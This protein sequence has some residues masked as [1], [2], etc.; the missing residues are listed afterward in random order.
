MEILEYPRTSHRAN[1]DTG[2]VIEG[3]E[4][5]DHPADIGFRV[6]ARTLPE[7]FAKSAAA[8]VSLIVDTK[9][10]VAHLE[11]HLAATGSD[12]ESLLVN[13]LNEILYYTDSE[14]IVFASFEIRTLDATRIEALGRGEH[15]DAAKHPAKLDV[16]AVTYHQLK[17]FQDADGWTSEV[18]VDV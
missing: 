8:L 13:W 11:I 9:P 18:Y 4:L 6:R 5:L 14:S 12:Y 3:V 10:A 1:R 2:V 16:K 15:R 7:L 17:L